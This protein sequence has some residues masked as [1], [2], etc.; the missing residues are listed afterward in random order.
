VRTLT[1]PIGH[2]E[3]I[4][5]PMR[6]L[7]RSDAEW[8]EAVQTFDHTAFRLELRPHYDEPGE[9][10]AAARFVDGDR[11]LDRSDPGWLS[12][13][14]HISAA[15]A[16]GKR[17]ERVRVFEDPPT[18]YQRWLRWV[19]QLNVEAG[20]VMRYI[21]RQRAE[22]VGLVPKGGLLEDWWLLDS[23]RLVVMTWEPSGRRVKDE[24]DSAPEAVAAAC[25][26]RDIAIHHSTLQPV[27]GPWEETE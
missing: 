25:A 10:E 2:L 11:T 18:G 15:V 19:S 1:L 13:M 12:W 5:L 6:Q 22:E 7:L 9:F 16:A 21:T 20:E 27:D 23:R 8:S 3:R 26:L 17:V 4:L 14:D 24:L